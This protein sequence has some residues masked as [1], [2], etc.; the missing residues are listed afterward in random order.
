MAPPDSS[1]PGGKPRR[2]LPVIGGSPAAEDA[3]RPRWHWS[4][5]VALGTLFGWLLVEMVAAGPLAE[6]LAQA[7]RHLLVSAIH[8]FALALPATL[9]GALAGRVGKRA[10]WIDAALGAVGLI[11]MVSILALIRLGGGGLWLLASALAAVAAGG[12]AA[13]GFAIGRR[14]PAHEA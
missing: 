14:K 13:L 11:G 9:A 2:R 8:L 12:G 1:S 7:G 4:I 5:I 6:P 10:R 3:A